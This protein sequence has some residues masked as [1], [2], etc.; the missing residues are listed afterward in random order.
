MRRIRFLCFMAICT[1]SAIAMD[2]NMPPLIPWA[3]ADVSY[4]CDSTNA[5]PTYQ[6]LP[7]SKWIQAKTLLNTNQLPLVALLALK[8]VSNADDWG[9]V[10]FE[11]PINYDAVKADKSSEGQLR[12]GFLNREG[13][14]VECCYSDYERATNG[15]CLVWWSINYDSPGR[16][17]IRA[18]LIYHDGLN[19]IIII[20]SPLPFYSSNVCRFP[21]GSTLFDSTGASI[22]AKLRERVATYHIDLETL[23]GKHIKTIAGNTTNGAIDVEWNLVGEHGEKFKNNSFIGLFFVSYPDDSHTNTPAKTQF[24]KIGT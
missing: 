4:I 17:E 20:G 1:S 23:E 21:E 8:Q 24:N 5:E 11:L 9:I 19:S 15:N 12:L 14:F 22:E 6:G 13:D 18:R 10:N 7:I 16:H 2:S 3:E